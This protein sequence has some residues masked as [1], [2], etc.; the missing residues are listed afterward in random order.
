ML[1]S[2][3]RQSDLFN[4]GILSIS[5]ASL[6]FLFSS[7]ASK[8]DLPGISKPV[9]LRLGP[10]AIVFLL[11]TAVLAIVAAFQFPLKLYLATYLSF[12][13]L[14]AASAVLLCISLYFLCVTIVEIKQSWRR[15]KWFLVSYVLLFALPPIGILLFTKLHQPLLI[16]TCV[17]FFIG[18]FISLSPLG[19]LN[20]LRFGF[21]KYEETWTSDEWYK[22]IIEHVSQMEPSISHSK[23]GNDEADLYIYMLLRRL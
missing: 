15:E 7:E 22:K 12:G 10:L 11:A 1:L 3:P 17:G 16:S 9:I 13:V 6:V 4:L 8:R 2:L 18:Y 19:I 5:A 14:M 21:G 23:N 20:Y